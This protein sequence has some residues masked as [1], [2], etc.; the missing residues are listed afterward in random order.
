MEILI[1]LCSATLRIVAGAVTHVLPWRA[2][3]GTAECDHQRAQ[4]F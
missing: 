1:T 4:T 2:A 3:H